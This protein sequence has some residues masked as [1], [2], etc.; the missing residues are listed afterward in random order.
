MGGHLPRETLSASVL[1]LLVGIQGV[2][3]GVADTGE[4]RPT[5]V[6]AIGE[7]LHKILGLAELLEKRRV[8]DSLLERRGG[9]RRGHRENCW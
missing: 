8:A 5:N 9:D 3:L 2:L 6:R 4:A 1:G 7:V